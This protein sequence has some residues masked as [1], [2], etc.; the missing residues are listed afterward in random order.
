MWQK[1]IEK[2]KKERECEGMC[3]EREKRG[4]QR[5]WNTGLLTFWP[6]YAIKIVSKSFNFYKI[7]L[8]RKFIEGAK[9]V[10]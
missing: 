9:T 8:D 5:S 1:L 7:L 3:M 2:K 10:L 6:E 4:L